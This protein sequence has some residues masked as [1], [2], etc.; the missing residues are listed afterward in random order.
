[1]LIDQSLGNVRWIV[2]GGRRPDAFLALGQMAAS[3]IREVVYDLP[4]AARVRAALRTTEGRAQLDALTKA[5]RDR[6]PLA[7]LE[8]AAM[9]KG[10]RLDLED[11]LVLTLRG[12]LPGAAQTGCSDFGWTDGDRA[13]FGHNEDGD[14]F[15]AGRSCL[16]TL[17]L[18]D[19]PA[20]TTWWYPGFLPGNTFWLNDHGMVVGVD[21]IRIL[22]S[23]VAPG[24]GFVARGLQA[25]ASHREALAY[26]RSHPAAGG[27][28]YAVG[29]MLTPRLATI[30]HGG[31]E[32]AYHEARP[33]TQSC[34]WHTNHL[35]HLP[36]GMDRPSRDSLARASMLSA[37]QVPPH[38]DTGWILDVLVGTPEHPG[39]RATGG[40]DSSLTLCTL[41]VD[42]AAAQATILPHAG[43]PIT[44]PARDL[45]R[46]DSS[47]ARVLSLDHGGA[48]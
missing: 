12:D 25:V 19:E 27:F 33:P 40:S 48:E 29:Q 42:L 28:S 2:V 30:E 36:D 45:V 37:V 4:D 21:A 1:M 5:S 3:H 13:L 47:H 46:G 26:L 16:L 43:S 31:T 6:H 38:P 35:R 44:L 14:P 23:S 11:L 24:R 34:Q 17:R 10:A 15:L 7:L 18:D 41:A 22:D 8:L 9:A 32:V 20:V 39:V